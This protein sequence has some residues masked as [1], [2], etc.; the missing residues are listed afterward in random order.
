ML[1]LVVVVVVYCCIGVGVSTRVGA[2][3]GDC[4]SKLCAELPGLS[5][6]SFEAVTQVTFGLLGGM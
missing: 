1:L 2:G 6:A 3:V 5:S 4:V